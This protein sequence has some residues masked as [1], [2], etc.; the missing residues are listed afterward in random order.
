[1]EN[2]KSSKLEVLIDNFINRYSVSGSFS[3]SDFEELLARAMLSDNKD[4]KRVSCKIIRRLRLKNLIGYVRALLNDEDPIIRSLS[5][6]AIAQFKDEQSLDKVV[7]LYY[8]DNKMVKSSSILALGSIDRPENYGLIFKALDDDVDDVRENA[9]IALSWINYYKNVSKLLE[10]YDIEKNRNIKN[11]IIKA[12]SIL[13]S[14]EINR[15][16]EEIVMNEHDDIIVLSA[17]NSLYKKGITKYVILAN[18]ILLKAIND[19]HRNK[20]PM[21]LYR[22][23]LYNIVAHN[24]WEI[25]SINNE[26]QSNIY[27]II[28]DDLVYKYYVRSDE[29]RKLAISALKNL[30]FNYHQLV[31]K[32]FEND[33]SNLLKV[34][35]INFLSNS[36]VD[37]N[38]KLLLLEFLIDN[39]RVVIEQALFAILDSQLVK[40]MISHINER[41]FSMEY[42]Y[43]KL[44]ALAIIYSS[45]DAFKV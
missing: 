11:R 9:I 35:L 13:S 23:N 12:F 44:I 41:I 39:D 3:K 1:M 32:L 18:S 17:I 4:L 2:I 26:D 16:L 6:L 20:K 22:K 25:K 28:E 21:D 40:A 37:K 24:L 8:S 27:K 43:L 38:L 33:L 14:D 42:S 36:R 34:E 15:K 7:E 31:I 5:L 19:V 30:N 10:M 29:V 45:I